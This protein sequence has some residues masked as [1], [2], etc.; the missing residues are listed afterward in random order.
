MDEIPASAF[1]MAIDVVPDDID[2]MNHVNNVVYLKWMIRAGLAHSDAVGY[3]ISKFREMGGMFV[4]RRHEID[5]L[6]SA[7]LNDRLTM[8]TWSQPMSGVKATRDYILTRDSDGAKIL[9]AKTFWV[10]INIKT[11]R[12][13]SIPATVSE[14]FTK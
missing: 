4:V 8:V 5:Y 9:T 3:P 11:G 12:P 14:A 7:L 2:G 1:R 13:I 6:K 10:Y